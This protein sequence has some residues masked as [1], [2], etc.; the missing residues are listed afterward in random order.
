MHVTA[1]HKEAPIIDRQ[2]PMNEKSVSEEFCG[3]LYVMDHATVSHR[4]LFN[5]DFL[6]YRIDLNAQINFLPTSGST[7]YIYSTTWSSHVRTHEAE[8]YCFVALT[9]TTIQHKKMNVTR[10]TEMGKFRA[11]FEMTGTGKTRINHVI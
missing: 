11:E 10:D 8:R 4:F 5:I 2:N 6:S 3:G 9:R 1:F 7:R